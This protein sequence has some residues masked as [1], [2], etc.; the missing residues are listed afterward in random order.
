MSSL[1]DYTI[2]HRGLDWRRLFETW[3]WLLPGEF[4]VWI[5]NRFGDLFLVLEDGSVHMLDIGRGTLEKVA[6]SRDHFAQRID[7]AANANDWLMIPLVD[8]LAGKGITLEPGQCYSYKQLPVLG[9]GYTLENAKVVVIEH[10]Y[11][12]FGPIH[13]ALKDVPDGTKVT[14]DVE[15]NE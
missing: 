5:M 7:E 8:E 9:G 4:T 13:H 14:F 2:D 12:T 10:H 3:R 6:D 15:E 1:Q 11:R